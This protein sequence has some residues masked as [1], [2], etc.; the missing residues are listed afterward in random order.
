MDSGTIFEMMFFFVVIHVL[1]PCFL[2]LI[3]WLCT[4]FIP[5]TYGKIKRTSQS[6][7]IGVTE[8]VSRCH[9]A[10]VWSKQNVWCGQHGIRCMESTMER[11]PWSLRFDAIRL[12]DQYPF[13]VYHALCL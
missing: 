6:V 5:M 2:R 7:C 10:R 9:R 8:R 12:Y 13:G 11:N 3:W 4:D 1:C